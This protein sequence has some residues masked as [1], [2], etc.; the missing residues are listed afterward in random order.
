MLY[1]ILFE[2]NYL[3]FYLKLIIF[4]TST[5]AIVF[6]LTIHEFSH[7]FVA[8]KLGDPTAKSLGRLTFNPL[9]HIDNYG[10]VCFLLFGFGWARPVPI[11]AFN[12]KKIKRDAF[13]VSI[14]GVLANFIVLFLAYPI[15]LL[16]AYWYAV[17]Q[18]TILLFFTYLFRFL[19]E[20]NL[21]LM[22]FNLLPIYPLDGFNAIASQLKY[23]NGFVNFMRK[24]GSLILIF[25]IIAFSYTD[26]FS[27]LVTYVGYPIV[28]FWLLIFQGLL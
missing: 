5:I 28:K 18:V 4:F 25:L 17:S 13:L 9:A 14:A 8:N 26:V 1:S 21:V 11:N 23:D 10:L 2:L 3:P 19:F 20:I 27:N 7:A 24:Y 16:F 15:Y 12:F 6:A 22:V